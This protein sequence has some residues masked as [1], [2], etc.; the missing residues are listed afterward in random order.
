MPELRLPLSGDVT[1]AINPWTWFLRL[2]E[3][4]VGL[5]NINLGRSSDP[6]L[7]RQI[8]ED[9]GS[10]GRQ[11]GRLGDALRVLIR[12]VPLD[13]LTI[14]EQDAIASCLSQL[15]A[16]DRLKR[17]RGRVPAVDP[18]TTPTTQET[19]ALSR[20]EDRGS[21]PPGR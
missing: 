20:I 15:D 17:K 12:H 8:L 18:L 1:Q 19:A 9:I 21:L 4:Q 11:L 13:D 16:V 5:V 3:A 14:D 10:Y 2:S 7:E 6:E